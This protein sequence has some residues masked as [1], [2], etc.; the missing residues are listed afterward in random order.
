MNGHFINLLRMK[1][2]LF[3]F[4]FGVVIRRFISI[5]HIRIDIFFVPDDPSSLVAHWSNNQVGEILHNITKVITEAFHLVLETVTVYA[6]LLKTSL[7]L[8]KN[9]YR[10]EIYTWKRILSTRASTI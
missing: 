8:L 4:I 3:L 9:V 6:K 10:K 5:G 7:N 1:T 2:F